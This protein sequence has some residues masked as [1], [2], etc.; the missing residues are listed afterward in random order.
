MLGRRRRCRERERD[1]NRVE[2]GKL[3]QTLA[4]PGVG[5]FDIAHA[6]ELLH[7]ARADVLVQQRGQGK[8][9]GTELCQCQQFHGLGER[10]MEPAES[11]RG[12]CKCLFVH[13]T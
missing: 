3:D 10:R 4:G 13:D 9:A 7:H 2:D 1:T 8:G 11:K 12:G 5:V 6:V